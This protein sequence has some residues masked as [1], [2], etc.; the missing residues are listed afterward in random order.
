MAL[1]RLSSSSSRR[2]LESTVAYTQ[3]TS[4]GNQY[5]GNLARTRQRIKGAVSAYSLTELGPA[6]AHVLEAL[7]SGGAAPKVGQPP[8]GWRRRG[9]ETLL[10]GLNP[11]CRQVPQLVDECCSYIERHGLCT[12]GIFRVG[13]SRKRVKQLREAYDSGLPAPL[14]ASPSVHDVAAL[15]K[16]FLR[17]L[18]DPL[19]TRALTPAFLTSQGLDS[20]LRRHILGL[21]ICLLPPCHAGTLLRLLSTLTHVAHHAETIG[22]EIHGNRMTELNLATVLG[23]T[24]VWSGR[25]SQ[26]GPAI[27]LNSTST[28]NLVRSLIQSQHLLF[29]V[30]PELQH[31]VLLRLMETDADVVEFLLRR[32]LR[33]QTDGDLDTEWEDTVHA[34]R[35]LSENG[36]VCPSDDSLPREEGERTSEQVSDGENSPYDNNSPIL[37]EHRRNAMS[38]RL[39]HAQSQPGSAS[40]ITGVV[41]PQRHKHMAAWLFSA[42]EKHLVERG[43][44]SSPASESSNTDNEDTMLETFV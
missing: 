37:G 4:G 22:K 10:L 39:C 34:P 43:P 13:G 18:P 33:S 19:L 17:S 44:E 27:A 1:P 36:A 26:Q 6:G 11:L 31:G 9:G 30:S 24:L 8:W 23:P 14:A 42:S 7:H 15:L 21:L 35:F 28:I 25:G 2:I 5:V 38:S 41:S 3:Q 32:R 29:Q 12:E 16:E 40:H 20:A